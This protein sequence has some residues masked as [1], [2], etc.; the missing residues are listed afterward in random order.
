[1]TNYDIAEMVLGSRKAEST[2]RRV[3]EGYLAKGH[4]RSVTGSAP[5]A[6]GSISSP[7]EHRER[8]KGKRFVITSAQNNTFIHEKFLDSLLAYCDD[9]DAQ[10]IVSGFYYNKNGFQNGKREDAW[11]DKRILPYMVNHSFTTSRW[12]SILWRTEYPTYGSE[13]YVWSL[14]LHRRSVCD[15]PSC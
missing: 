7:E 8:A 3:W 6:G 5:I 10:L 13:S 9:K 2:V 15:H 1:M 11:F 14:Q 4:Y 12:F